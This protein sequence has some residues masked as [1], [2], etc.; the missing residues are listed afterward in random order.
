MAEE[1]VRLFR[2]F[3]LVNEW[4]KFAEAK[5]IALISLNGAA[6]V[7]MQSV[8]KHYNPTWPGWGW[9][10]LWLWT[11]TVCC[12]LSLLVGVAS[13]FP[14]TR[15]PPAFYRSVPDGSTGAIFF[16]HLARMTPEDV[17]RELAPGHATSEHSRYLLDMAGQVVVN[18]KN[19]RRKFALFTIAVWLT[20]C[21]V[22]TPVG[23]ALFYMW[24]WDEDL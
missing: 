14:K 6:I 11:A 9:T 2:S 12:G 3:Q 18:S 10:E 23:A 19:A 15:I 13:L 4:L 5:N 21:G 24:F 16:G 7:G 8:W 1:D 17:L 20:L 22:A